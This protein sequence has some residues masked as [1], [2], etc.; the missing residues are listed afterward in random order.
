M[1]KTQSENSGKEGKEFNCP[2]CQINLFDKVGMMMHVEVCDAEKIEESEE[3]IDQNTFLVPT[4]R[5]NSGT[6]GIL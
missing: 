6:V 2:F 3:V 4:A 5:T 1:Y